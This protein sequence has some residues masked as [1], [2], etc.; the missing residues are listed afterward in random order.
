HKIRALLLAGVRA[1][2][3]WRQIG[4]K[5]RQ[6]IFSRKAMLHQTKQNL[7]RV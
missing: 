3:L 5:R 2:V 7:Q 6:L 1:A 4:G